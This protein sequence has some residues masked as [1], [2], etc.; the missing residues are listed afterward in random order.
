MWSSVHR[1]E[2]IF[3]A[4]VAGASGM[5]SNS[6]ERWVGS[7]LSMRHQSTSATEK[8]ASFQEHGQ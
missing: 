6:A 4:I 7:E 2:E 1:K 3:A 5:E 8:G